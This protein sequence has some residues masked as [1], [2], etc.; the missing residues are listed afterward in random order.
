[1]VDYAANTQGLFGTA[2]TGPAPMANSHSYNFT[3]TPAGLGFAPRT[4][5][6]LEAYSSGRGPAVAEA[7]FVARRPNKMAA[8]PTGRPGPGLGSE[9]EPS[10]QSRCDGHTMKECR[11]EEGQMSQQSQTGRQ[12]HSVR[13]SCGKLVK[14]ELYPSGQAFERQSQTSNGVG[15][16]PIALSTDPSSFL[17]STLDLFSEASTSAL[18]KAHTHTTHTHTRRALSGSSSMHQK[19]S[20]FMVPGSLRWVRTALCRKKEGLTLPVLPI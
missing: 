19:W 7:A 15:E 17:N 4:P 12:L 18:R 2:Q 11:Q 6:P 1:M 13:Q 14:E 9:I 8:G 20:S 3:G 16:G 5:A 10:G